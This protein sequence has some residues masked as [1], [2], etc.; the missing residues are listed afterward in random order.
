MYPDLSIIDTISK[1]VLFTPRAVKSAHA[2]SSMSR[3]RTR[4]RRNSLDLV[5]NVDGGNGR[6]TPGTKQCAGDARWSRRKPSLSGFFRIRCNHPTVS[7]SSSD[8]E[9]TRCKW[10]R[11]RACPL[12]GEREF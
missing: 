2:S 9:S 3:H 10:R 6:K 8:E 12:P 1:N 4:H 5:D 11:I 7:Q